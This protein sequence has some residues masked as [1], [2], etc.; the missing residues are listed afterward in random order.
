MRSIG[1]GIL[2]V[3]VGVPGLAFLAGITFGAILIPVAGLLILAPFVLVYSVLW[4]PWLGGRAFPER[5]PTE[6]AAGD[7]PGSK[8]R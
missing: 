5:C 3:I 1:C 2:A 6:T 7:C 4:V 8:A